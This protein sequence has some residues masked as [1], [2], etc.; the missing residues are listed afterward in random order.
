[1][2]FSQNRHSKQKKHNLYNGKLNVTI[3]L[4]FSQ[5]NSST[6]AAQANNFL[7]NRSYKNRSNTR[8]KERNGS[9]LFVCAL[10]TKQMTNNLM[11][12]SKVKRKS[13]REK[14]VH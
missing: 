8:K 9:D 10:F 14:K 12:I 6:R 5:I 4:H 7:S 3:C 1:M 11:D 13:D 2:G